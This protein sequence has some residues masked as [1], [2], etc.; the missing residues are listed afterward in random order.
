LRL[1]LDAAGAARRQD[2][3]SERFPSSQSTAKE[4]PD[5]FR[6]IVI[7]RAATPMRPAT[8]KTPNSSSSL[9][10]DDAV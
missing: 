8:A 2:G 9:L 1:N 7:R 6:S 4:L 5:Y 10:M 3:R